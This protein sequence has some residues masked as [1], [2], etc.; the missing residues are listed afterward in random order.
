MIDTDMRQY[1]RGLPVFT[2]ELPV[3][4]ASG[5]PAE[6]ETLFAEWLAGA[7][8]GGV[9]EPHAMTLSTVGTD[10]LPN[11]RVLILKNVDAGGWQFAGHAASPKGRELDRHP[12]AA[13]TFHWPTQARQI[14]VRGRVR[15]EP[16]ERSAADFLARPAGSRAEAALG[17]QS[18]PLT[19]RGTLDRALAQARERLDADPGF[20]AP[21]WT[22]Y[23]LTADEVEFWQ[24]DKDRK[25]HR[26][27]YAR[28]TAGWTHELLWP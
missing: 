14:R 6:P 4:D 26:L 2:G 9:R 17:R 23:T 18:R 28:S 7:V 19:D 11:A 22:L 1:L 5:V 20:V 16:A 12:A 15:P 27:R 8:E 24:G 13:L 10:G 21:E 25:H 3:F